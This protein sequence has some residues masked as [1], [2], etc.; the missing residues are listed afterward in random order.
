[1]KARVKENRW[2]DSL[3]KP[4]R[5]KVLY[6]GRAS[7][8]SWAMARALVILMYLGDGN[9]FGGPLRIVCFR[10]VQL[11]LRDSSKENMEQQIKRMGLLDYFTITKTEIIHENGSR[12]TFRGLSKSHGTAK[13]V[14]SLEGV[15]IAWVDEAHCM[16]RESLMLLE[17][18]IR[19][20]GSEIW[21]CFNPKLRSDPVYQDYVTNRPSNSFIRKVNYTDNEFLSPDG[22]V[23]KQALEM[24]ARNPLRYQHVWL[25]EPDD[26]GEGYILLPM[27]MIEKCISAWHLRPEGYIEEPLQIGYDLA[28]VK[29]RCAFVARRGPC[30]VHHETWKGNV[31]TLSKST[32]RVH[33]YA[34]ENDCYHLW[35]DV[36]GM[37]HHVEGE[38]E[39]LSRESGVP[40]AHTGVNFGGTVKGPDTEYLPGTTNRDFFGR[41]RDQM[42]WNL[43][44][45]AESTEKLLSGESVNKYECLFIDPSIPDLETLTLDLAQPEYD[46]S[47]AGKRVIEKSP[48][49]AP[50]PDSFDAT[51]LAFCFDIEYGLEA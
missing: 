16:S 46:D 13:T 27:P 39:N 17:P 8:K 28:A 19:K 33:R 41:R 42:G 34:M 20:P 24:K 12:V 37:G 30:I 15:D 31:M 44:L 51:C 29:D 18:T 23:W 22:E 50:S 35:Y 11:S 5:R 36:G 49:K 2:A 21:Y 38:M 43:R 1:M 3:L 4:Y 32:R 6:G 26:L 9:Y 7:G 48:G 45:R 40:Y 10:E 47:H 25:G 14:P